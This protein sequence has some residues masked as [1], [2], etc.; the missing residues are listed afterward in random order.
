VQPAD[1]L[2]PVERCVLG[3]LQRLLILRRGVATH[4]KPIDEWVFGVL[5]LIREDRPTVLQMMNNAPLR[6][7]RQWWR[8]GGSGRRLLASVAVGGFHGMDDVSHARTGLLLPQCPL[9]TLTGGS[10]G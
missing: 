6:T 1:A 2:C 3:D 4:P 5:Q 10:G 7:D 8:G 9:P